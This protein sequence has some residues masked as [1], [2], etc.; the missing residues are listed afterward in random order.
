MAPAGSRFLLVA[1][2]LVG[3]TKKAEDWLSINL[4]L[5]SSHLLG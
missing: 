5:L 2:R 3:M 4:L 1:A